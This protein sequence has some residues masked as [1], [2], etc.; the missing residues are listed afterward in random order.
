MRKI[1]IEL[2]IDDSAYTNQEKTAL[3]VKMSDFVESMDDKDLKCTVGEVT[4]YTDNNNARYIGIDQKGD[5]KKICE[6]V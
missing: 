5:R 6:D 2:E 4:L 3:N 1:Y